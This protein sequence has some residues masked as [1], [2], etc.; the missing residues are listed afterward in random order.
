MEEFQENLSCCC[1][2]HWCWMRGPIIFLD[3]SGCFFNKLVKKIIHEIE[4]HY[5]LLSY[6]CGCSWWSAKNVLRQSIVLYQCSGA[7]YTSKTLE[8]MHCSQAWLS[9][10]CIKMEQ[11]KI[12]NLRIKLIR[13]NN[14]QR[15]F[16]GWGIAIIK[17][18]TL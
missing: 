12:W 5:S 18:K 10:V 11:E 17:R 7:R 3:C 13:I 4:K 2:W 9:K 1:L 8:S 15:T 16:N 6:L 14:F